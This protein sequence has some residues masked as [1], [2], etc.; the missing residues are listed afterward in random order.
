MM[1]WD[2]AH[3][4]S[5]LKGKLK[6]Q[7]SKLSDVQLDSIKGKRPALLSTI[8][9]AYGVSSDEAEKQ[10]ASFEKLH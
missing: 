7:W 5:A 8:Q 6:T 4:D 1:N 2:T 3:N 9:S 10:V